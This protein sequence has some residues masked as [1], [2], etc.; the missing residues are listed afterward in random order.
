MN[1]KEVLEREV[2]SLEQEY[3]AAIGDFKDK[4]M[5]MAVDFSKFDKR[6]KEKYNLLMAELNKLKEEEVKSAKLPLKESLEPVE[7][8]STKPVQETPPIVDETVGI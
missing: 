1:T 3:N 6:M 2:M 8:Y 5:Q 4:F 7:E